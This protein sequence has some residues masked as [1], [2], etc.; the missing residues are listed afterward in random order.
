MQ[1]F[2]SST[3]V[4]RNCRQQWCLDSDNLA[5]C[6]VLL[7]HKSLACSSVITLLAIAIYQCE[8]YAGASLQA[9]QL[10]HV[11]NDQPRGL[12]QVHDRCAARLLGNKNC[13][14][15]N[16]RSLRLSCNAVACSPPSAFSPARGSGPPT[17]SNPIQSNPTHWQAACASGDSF[18]FHTAMCWGVEHWCAAGSEARTSAAPQPI[19]RWNTY[20]LLPW[21]GG[22]PIS[23]S[24]SDPANPPA[25]CTAAVGT[26]SSAASPALTPGVDSFSEWAAPQEKQE[27]P[28]ALFVN[29]LA[30]TKLLDSALS[31]AS[32]QCM[33]I[34][35]VLAA[36]YVQ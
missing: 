26:S 3:L 34:R 2:S 29:A 14:L 6:K 33:G 21:P 8:H 36:G 35:P 13:S 24:Y 28:A 10:P 5:S 27:E 12:G 17:Q 18:S 16:C 30:N 7:S 32:Q 23:F 4:L 9:H 1:P 11:E 19:A 22:M 25:R 20:F 15:R 31:L